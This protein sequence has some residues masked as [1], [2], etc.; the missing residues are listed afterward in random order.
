VPESAFAACLARHNAYLQEATGH[1]DVGFSSG[2]HDIKLLLLRFAE[3]KSF[4]ED[5]GGG[6]PE[7]NMHLIPYLFHT[8]LYVLNTTRAATK[9]SNSVDKFLFASHTSWKEDAFAVEGSYYHLVVSL[10]VHQPDKWME[11]RVL[12]L[13]RV[14]GLCGI[15]SKQLGASGF[16]QYRAGLIF[17][18]LIHGLYTIVFKDVSGSG[19]WPSILADYIRKNDEPLVK[20]TTAL[21][22]LYQQKLLTAQTIPQFLEILGLS[23]HPD[24]KDVSGFTSDLWNTIV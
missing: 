1:R 14:L 5:T 19:E 6:G 8:A 2:V 11:N 9:E 16:T 17:L 21:L 13:K 24:L 7:S 3:E 4:H 20:S 12:W 10:M 15:R 18:S 23:E 22:N